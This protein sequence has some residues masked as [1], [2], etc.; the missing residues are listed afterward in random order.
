LEPELWATEL[1]KLESSRA[2]KAS[3][4]EVGGASDP[5][6][7]RIAATSRDA[8]DAAEVE[9]SSVAVDAKDGET[10]SLSPRRSSIETAGAVEGAAGKGSTAGIVFAK[11]SARPSSLIST[12]ERGFVIAVA[13]A[14]S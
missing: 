8:D 12:G 9:C 2:P 7:P 11:G 10:E 4:V 13:D 3:D 1:P 6:S 5:A 14:A